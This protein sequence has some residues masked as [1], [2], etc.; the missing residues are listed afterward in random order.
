MPRPRPISPLTFETCAYPPLD[1]SDDD[2]LASDDDLDESAQAAKRQKIERIAESCR[3]G[4]PVFI[5]SASLRGPFEHNWKNPWKKERTRGGKATIA[6]KIKAGGDLEKAPVIQETDPREA[7]HRKDWSIASRNGMDVSSPV[8]RSSVLALDKNPDRSASSNPK[9]SNKPQ[10][11][12]KSTGRKSA[13][14]RRDASVSVEDQTFT[15]PGTADWLRKGGKRLN[16]GKFEPPSSP[17]PKADLRRARY[18]S[19]SVSNAIGKQDTRSPTRT[20]SPTTPRV[21][22]KPPVECA[23]PMSLSPALSPSRIKC[24]GST[25]AKQVVQKASPTTK[26]HAALSFRVASSTS[27]LPRFQYQ[28]L[29]AEDSSPGELSNLIVENPADKAPSVPTADDPDDDMASLDVPHEQE[30]AIGTASIQKGRQAE[31]PK[32]IQVANQRTE[33]IEADTFAQTSVEQNTYEQLP[34]AQQVPVAPGVS[35]RVTSLHS[36]AVPKENNS[37]SGGSYDTQLSTQAALRHAQKSFQDDLESSEPDYDMPSEKEDENGD[38]SLLAHETPFLNPA[39]SDRIMPS[40]F[41]RWDKEKAQAM[42]TQCMIDAATPFTFSTGKKPNQ[43]RDLSPVVGTSPGI[44]GM[45]AAFSPARSSPFAVDEYHT[46]PTNDDQYAPGQQQSGLALGQQ[47]T[48]QNSALPFALTGSTPNTAQDGQGG[49]QRAESF[50]LSQAIADDGSWLQ[51]S[52]DF[53]NDINHPHPSTKTTSSTAEH[54]T[55]MDLDIS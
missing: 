39:T 34:S 3:G 51:Q 46:A 12:P 14:S 48:T 53:M 18:K 27:Q 36:T 17:T 9:P 20:R 40:D 6:G 44:T 30:N 31:P 24:P 43:F 7:K 4:A 37:A 21:S 23:P 50:N 38:E 25:I 52:F 35:D 32:D 11:P 49:F 22:E 28:R 47:S 55:A 8:D 54:P 10:L 41:S 26:N 29:N 45:G 5:L 2:L 33:S 42:S 15:A 1:P 19:S 16:F 13:V